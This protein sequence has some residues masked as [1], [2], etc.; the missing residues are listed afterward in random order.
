[1]QLPNASRDLKKSPLTAKGAFF[2]RHT[3]FQ[4]IKVIGYFT[5]SYA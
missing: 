4:A 3:F 5:N 2:L 1:M